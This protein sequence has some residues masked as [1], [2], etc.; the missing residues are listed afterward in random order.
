MQFVKREGSGENTE[1]STT[2]KDLHLPFTVEGSRA[3]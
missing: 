2:L 1:N 3:N